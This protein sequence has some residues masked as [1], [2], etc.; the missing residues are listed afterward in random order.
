MKRKKQ[1]GF[2]LV[3]LIAVIGILAVLLCV[4]VPNIVNY[5]QAS[6]RAAAQTEAQISADAVQRYLDDQRDRGQLS[7][8]QVSNLMG[9]DLS[10][11]D[12]LLTDYMSGGQTDARIVSVGVD[13]KIG[14]LK[15]LVYE[16]RYCQANLSIDEDGGRTLDVRTK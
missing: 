3:E 6:H 10:D 1:A 11:P 5:I 8:S 7:V 13:M 4:A 16:N 9:L 12:G 2:T 15:N 14:R